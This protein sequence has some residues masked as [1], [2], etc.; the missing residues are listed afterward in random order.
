MVNTSGLKY[1]TIRRGD[2]QC[3]TK[4]FFTE[5]DK[6]NRKDRRT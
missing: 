5:K 1:V 3:E 4:V 2:I 6:E